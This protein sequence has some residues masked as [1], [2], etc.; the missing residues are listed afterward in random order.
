M[1]FELV[2]VQE[3]NEPLLCLAMRAEV[4]KTT[5]TALIG[6]GAD[7][8]ASNDVRPGSA[9]AL[10]TNPK[11]MVLARRPVGHHCSMLLC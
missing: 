3:S 10:V 4:D 6:A 5:L 9:A 1:T 2:L 7:V 11:G 8:N